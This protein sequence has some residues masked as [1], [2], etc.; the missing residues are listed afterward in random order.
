MSK[1]NLYQIWYRDE[2]LQFLDPG[3]IPWDNRINQRPEWCEYWIMRNAWRD[4]V[5]KFDDL[6]GFFSWKYREKIDIDSGRISGFIRAHPGADCYLFS[7]AVFQVAFYRNV[8]EQA[9]NST[10]GITRLA[11]EILNILGYDIDLET[12]VDHHC[13]TAFSNYWI[14][15]KPFWQAYFDFMEPVYDLVESMKSKEGSL[16]WEKKYGSFGGDSFVQALPLIPYLVER[17]FSVFVKM[18]SEFNIVSWEYNM[19]E[20]RER[21]HSTAGMVQMANWSKF[22]FE[23][24]NDDFY[25]NVYCHLRVRMASAIGKSLEESNGLIIR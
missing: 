16:L 20:M 15:T 5:S 25:I 3:M 4:P 12:T 24:T 19:H 1:I 14:A 10:P 18:K 6:T 22:L 7:P 23:E 2:H 13:S 11:Q 21:V 9:E 17:M 8:W